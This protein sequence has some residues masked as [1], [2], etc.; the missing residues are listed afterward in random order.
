MRGIRKVNLNKRLLVFFLLLFI[1]LFTSSAGGVAQLVTGFVVTT[2]GLIT[3]VFNPLVGLSITAGGLGLLSGGYSTMESESVEKEK[4]KL[5]EQQGWIDAYNNAYSSYLQQLEM[6]NTVSANIT[7]LEG[8]ILQTQTNISSFDQALTRWQ[9]QYDQQLLSLQQQGESSYSALM[10]N[11]QGVELVNATRGQTGGSA[12]LV[13]QSQ[14]EQLERLAG[15][16]LRLDSTGGI[17]GTALNE[18][19]LDMLAGRNEMI[20]NRNIQANALLQYRASYL[21]YKNQLDTI[22]NGILTAWK[23]VESNRNQAINAGV[24]PSKVGGGK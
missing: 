1:I 22:R 12:S 24:D 14:L 23:N 13:A 5:E 15:A 16:D 6:E 9:S 11:W 10:Q 19:R 7:S 18:F 4:Q 3:T 8:S 21:N 20:G 17:Y 2:A